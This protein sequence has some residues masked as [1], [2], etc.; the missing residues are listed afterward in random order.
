MRFGLGEKWSADGGM[1]FFL[2]RKLVPPDRGKET[3]RRRTTKG[4]PKI[5]EPKLGHFGGEEGEGGG[6]GEEDEEKSKR[7]AVK[8]QP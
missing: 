4:R 5:R 8:S 7:K 1:R 6:G 2:S 3:K